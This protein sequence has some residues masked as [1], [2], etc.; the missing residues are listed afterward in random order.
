MYSA[1]K[2]QIENLLGRF[3]FK[4]QIYF[5]VWPN[6]FF[7]R[8]VEIFPRIWPLSILKPLILT[9]PAE[10]NG[11]F[12]W[13]SCATSQPTTSPSGYTVMTSALP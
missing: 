5:Q 11:F 9:E 1:E 10:L 4:R 2:F 6:V 13:A 3:R 12:W 8:L 7:W